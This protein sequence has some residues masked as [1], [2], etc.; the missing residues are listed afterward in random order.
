VSTI[1]PIRERYTPRQKMR[2]ATAVSRS[3]REGREQ[4]VKQLAASLRVSDRTLWRWFAEFEQ[5]GSQAFTP[6][7]RS[8]RG[9]SRFF[10]DNP[11]SGLFVA[12][13]IASGITAPS[14]IRA[15]MLQVFDADGVPSISTLRAFLRARVEKRP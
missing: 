15:E 2:A 11:S 7:S 9:Q 1:G 6:H 4:L 3:S 14:A 5:R 8:D 10:R 12:T 13:A